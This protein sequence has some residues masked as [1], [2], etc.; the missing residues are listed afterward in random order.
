MGQHVDDYNGHF[1]NYS[2]YSKTLRSWLVA[3]G[4]GGPVLLLTNKEAPEKLANSPYLELIVSLFVIGVAL[5]ILLAFLNK[6][7]AWNMYSGAYD[8]HLDLMGSADCE[9][10]HRSLNYRV[11]HWI[12]R[13]SWIDFCVDLGAMIS[14]S[15]A[16][17]IAL[18]TLL[19]TP[20]VT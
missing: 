17:W 8:K 4:I 12:N 19:A 1:S 20:Q 18:K 7:A 9:M 14:F 11:W 6:W 16:T 13:Q 3:Y 2:E 5:Q 10:R 15:I